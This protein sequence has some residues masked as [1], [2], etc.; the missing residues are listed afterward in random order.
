MPARGRQRLLL[1][2]L[3]VNPQTLSPWGAYWFAGTL[4]AFSLGGIWSAWA[5]GAEIA[6]LLGLDR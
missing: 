5:L 3:P 2:D 1:V 4:I 6:L